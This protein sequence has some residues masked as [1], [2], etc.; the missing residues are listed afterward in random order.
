MGSRDPRIDA[1]IARS[2][3]F[4]KPILTHIREVVH[5]ACPE[6]E[7]TMKWSSPHFM[8]HGMLCGMVAFKEHCGFGFWK[9]RLVLGNLLEGNESTA[10]Q[11][12]K[13]E[14][15]RD[16]PSKKVLI[17]HVKTAMRLNEEGTPAARVPKTASKGP[18]VVPDELTAALA[19]NKTARTAFEAFSPSHRREYCEWIA[20]AKRDETRAKRV[21]QAVEWIA[22][23]KGRNWKYERK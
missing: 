14:S 6:V 15:V 3:D 11:F 18:I 23:G 4:A 8:Y 16:L 19:R 2:A 17:G 22:E 20:D 5:A 12:G 1:Y 21:T 7:E 9:G 10:G 13:L